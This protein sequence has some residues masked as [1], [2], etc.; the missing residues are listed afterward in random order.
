MTRKSNWIVGCTL[1]LLLVVPISLYLLIWRNFHN[2]KLPQTR[3]AME[4][5]A[6]FHEKFN[7][8][9]LDGICK[10]TFNCGSSERLP[11]G[12]Q[13]VLRD[14]KSHCGAFGQVVRSD[15]EV[16]V[17]P[18]SIRAIYVSSFERG[19]LREIFFLR[20]FNGA[21]ELAGYAPTTRAGGSRPEECW[22][23]PL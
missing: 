5:V 21:L 19:V 9:D 17:E 15:V 8:G 3:Q 6:R 20:D 18:P 12:W 1:A 10:E 13:L 7:S 4:L 14:V 2:R 16:T 11:E 23:G 22:S